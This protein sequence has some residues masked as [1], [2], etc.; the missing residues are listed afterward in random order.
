MTSAMIMIMI[1]ILTIMMMMIIII[2]MIL[3]NK[4]WKKKK[5]NFR[6]TNLYFGSD[7]EISAKSCGV[8]ISIIDKVT[9]I[10]SE[11]IQYQQ[12]W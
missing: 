12:P 5:K 3:I 1:M 8:P 2:I 4:K 6:E 9:T 11:S 7:L 10:I